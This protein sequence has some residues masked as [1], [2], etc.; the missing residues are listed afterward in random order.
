[1]HR[2]L[3]GAGAR[4]CVC[5]HAGC[6]CVWGGYPKLWVCGYVYVCV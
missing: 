2:S 4:M 6:V 1:M 5:V 3:Q